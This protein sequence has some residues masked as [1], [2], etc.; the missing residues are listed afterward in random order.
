MLSALAPIAGLIGVQS[1]LLL[2]LIARR[3]PIFRDVLRH[4]F[5]STPDHEE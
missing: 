2:G 1:A 4:P 3:D 5:R